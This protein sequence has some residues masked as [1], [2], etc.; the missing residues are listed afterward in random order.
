M[1]DIL[2]MVRGLGPKN[3]QS[4]GEWISLRLHIEIGQETL[5]S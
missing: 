5:Y 2:E 3:P 1:T 4:F